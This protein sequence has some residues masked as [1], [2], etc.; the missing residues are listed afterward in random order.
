[1]STQRHLFSLQTFMIGVT[2]KVWWQILRQNRFA[3]DFPYWFR[4]LAATFAAPVNSLEKSLEDREFAS[5]IEQTPIEKDPIFLL[6]HWRS[7]TTHLH[8]LLCQDPQFAAPNNYQTARPHAFLRA[9]EKTFIPRM[10]EK[11]GI[12]PKVRPMDNVAVS[13]DS[14]QEDEQ[15]IFLACGLS[16]IGAWLFP[17][18]EPFYNRFFTFEEATEEERQTWKK[19]I[20]WVVKK[21]TLRNGG[22]QLVL[23]SPPH[24]SRIPLL[25]ELFP[26]A[27]FIHIHRHPYEVFRSTCH[28]YN[29]LVRHVNLQNLEES[30]ITKSVLDR[31]AILYEAFFASKSL[32]GEGRFFE[33]GYDALDKHPMEAMERLYQALDLGDFDA[34]RPRIASYLDTVQNYAKNPPKPLAGEIKK[35]IQK[36]WQS[37]FQAWGYEP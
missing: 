31:Y 7:G 36:R 19:T 34:L 9:H 2:W 29:T 17:R 8:Y 18:H 6:G 16:P 11:L 25:L 24:T 12:M 30:Q 21:L 14:P 26:K 4:A 35:H 28:F 1:M 22:R 5:A 33:M 32:V 15:G 3:V 10:I 20:L 13:L 27:K 23:K 37:S